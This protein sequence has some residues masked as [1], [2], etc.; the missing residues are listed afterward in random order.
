MGLEVVVLLVM[1]IGVRVWLLML[2][3]AVPVVYT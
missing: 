3:L 1:V 2:L